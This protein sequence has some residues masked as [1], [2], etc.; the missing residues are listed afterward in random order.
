MKRQT[1]IRT[2]ALLVAVFA[3]TAAV[4]TSIASTRRPAT[5]AQAEAAQRSAAG[6]GQASAPADA[7]VTQAGTS[8][9]TTDLVDDSSVIVIG[10]AVSNKSRLTPDGDEARTYYSV[11][12][13]EVLK[14]DVREGGTIDV[15]MRGGLVLLK[16][17]GTAVS[18]NN[19]LGKVKTVRVEVKGG[20]TPRM[21][22][23]M[24]GVSSTRYTQPEF[25]NLMVNG[26]T[27]LIFLREKSTA[28]GFAL[29]AEPREAGSA[30]SFIEEVRS[31]VGRQ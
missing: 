22:T 9:A 29:I 5:G 16:G 30:Q 12:V 26:E 17:N 6:G 11:A 27:Y 25:A 1:S 2:V 23:P 20:E 7:P 10:T 18:E 19:R 28:K 8:D 13:K 14:G 4:L 31:A 15:S 24:E 3:L 21:V